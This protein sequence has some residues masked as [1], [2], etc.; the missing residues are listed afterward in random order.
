[1]NEYFLEL[2][3]QLTILCQIWGGFKSFVQIKG[4]MHWTIFNLIFVLNIIISQNLM[5]K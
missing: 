1:M 5:C 2:V 3:H 4:Y